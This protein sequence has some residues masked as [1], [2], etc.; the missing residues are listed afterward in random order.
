[1]QHPSK[2]EK[3][4]GQW[5]AYV[6]AGKTK[7]ERNRRLSEVPEPVRQQVKNHVMTVFSINRFHANKKTR[8]K[9]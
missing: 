4:Q 5:N 2:S 9:R 8:P 3:S 6:A 7:E 1:M